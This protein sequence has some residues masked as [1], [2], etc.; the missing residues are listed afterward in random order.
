M[1]KQT[2]HLVVPVQVTP[3]EFILVIIRKGPTEIRPPQG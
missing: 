3:T 1:S 2:S